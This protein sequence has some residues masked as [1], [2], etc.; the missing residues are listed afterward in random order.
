MQDHV[1]RLR[2]YA[3][4]HATHQVLLRR[5]GIRGPS[6]PPPSGL[7][8]TP[9]PGTRK[10]Q[11]GPLPMLTQPPQPPVGPPRG[12]SPAQNPLSDRLHTFRRIPAGGTS[13]SGEATLRPPQTSRWF[14]SSKRDVPVLPSRPFLP[15]A[16]VRMQRPNEPGPGLLGL[17]DP[18][19][20]AQVGG[21]VRAVQS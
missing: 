12:Q 16:P 9:A 20:V 2:A 13:F 15:L 7:E 8:Q 14:V 18:V 3:R 21:G 10:L 17:D 19:V 5:R 6:G 4:Y 1:V 11:P